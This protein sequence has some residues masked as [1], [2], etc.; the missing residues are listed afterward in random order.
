MI[1]IEPFFSRPGPVYGLRF[2][3]PDKRPRF[4]FLFELPWN[5]FAVNYGGA[6]LCLK[7]QARAITNSSRTAR[8]QEDLGNAQHMHESQ[9]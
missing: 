1:L 3:Y 8:S 2:S 9:L 7:R 4:V 6:V 5:G